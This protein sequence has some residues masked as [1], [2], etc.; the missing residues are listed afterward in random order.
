VVVGSYYLN[1]GHGFIF[2]NGQYKTVD[3]PGAVNSGLTAISDN[4]LAVGTFWDGNVSHFDDGFE[5]D[6][7]H[8]IHID[9]N[10]S[11]WID[12]E[13]NGINDSGEIV[14]LY[15]DERMYHSF[16]YREGNFEPIKSPRAKEILVHGI[17]NS[18]TIVGIYTDISNSSHGFIGTPTFDTDFDADY[19][20][21]GNDLASI[22]KSLGAIDGEPNY[23]TLTDV[24]D[25]GNIDKQ[26]L[27]IFARDFGR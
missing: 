23:N 18:G 10:P 14:G 17:N 13:L 5:Y 26:D 6:G 12:A 16:I 27:R 8:F 7:T 4:G 3:Y 22:S 1:G 11:T 2:K 20:V 25:D 19:D 24:D 9:L 21:D 15:A